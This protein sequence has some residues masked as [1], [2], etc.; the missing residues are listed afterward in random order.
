[1]S[2][3][4]L[5][6]KVKLPILRH[7]IV[8]RREVLR[9][10]R[11]GFQ[12]GHLLSLVCAPAG[13]GK[14]TAVR[15]WIEELD[16]PVAWVTLLGPVLMFVFLLKITGVPPT[17]LRA[18]QSRGDHYREYQRTTSVFFPWFPKETAS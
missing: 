18:L 15:M 17:E 8:A 7:H 11:E 10:L 16:N 2:D 9:R 12:E 13:Y 5:L 6:S 14:T 1:M 3:P 4:L